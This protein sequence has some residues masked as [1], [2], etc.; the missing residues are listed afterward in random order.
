MKRTWLT[1]VLTSV[2]VALG[3]GAATTNL[4]AQ[5]GGP[6][7]SGRVA[8][9]DVVKVFAEYQKQKDLT[10]EINELRDAV[11]KENKDRRDKIDALQAELS[12]MSEDEPTYVRRG[13]DLLAMQIDYKNWM[14]L[15]QADMGREIG[16]WSIRLYKEIRATAEE[17][18][19]RDGWDMVFYRG[20]FETI[21]MDPEVIKE[22]IRS[23]HLLYA[24]PS[25]DITQAIVDKLN[26][27]YRTQPRTKM[28]MVP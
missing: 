7:L 5:G 3:I 17:I 21:S 6:P 9:V 15:K 8:C 10:E 26:K 24:N 14:D 18:G 28:L 23:T 27:D 20:E 2:A 12:R 16:I 25:A 1:G 13:H 22:Q 19:V 11:E 4:R